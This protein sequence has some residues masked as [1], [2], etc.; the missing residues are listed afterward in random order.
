MV[1]H[2][3]EGTTISAPGADEALTA[4]LA[5]LLMDAANEIGAVV[6]HVLTEFDITPSVAGVLWT[7][8]P[9]SDPLTMREI[10]AKLGCDPSTVSLTADKLEE[11]G[12][13]ARRPHPSDGRKRTLALTDNGHRLRATLSKRLA[14]AP[15]LAG[16]DTHERRQLAAL[17][18]KARA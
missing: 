1:K 11:V 9:S 13:I 17:L 4:D 16:L 12:L 2:E 18:V 15:V 6:A 7:L 3:R 8:D 10:A 14:E 5:R